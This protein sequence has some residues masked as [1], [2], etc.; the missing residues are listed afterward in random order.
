MLCLFLSFPI[1]LDG[2]VFFQLERANT[3]KVKR[4]SIGDVITFRTDE[5]NEHWL[6][7]KIVNILPDDNALVFYDKI[8]YLDEMTHFRYQRDWA[9]ITGNTLMRFGVAWLSFAGIIEGLR[10]LDAIETQYEFGTDTA[11][12]GLSA[13]TTGF[14]T[15]KLWQTAMV[16]L[17]NRNRVRILDI[18]F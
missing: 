5:Y 10:R 9:R 1:F 7:G 8:M 14:L 16:K 3:T 6:T 11:I 12:I 13:L 18:Q 17:N 4:Y 15:K 2:Q